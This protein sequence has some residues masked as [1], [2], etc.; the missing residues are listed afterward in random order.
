[1]SSAG[2]VGAAGRS[3][4]IAGGGPG[5]LA[6]ALC[7]SRTGWDVTVLERGPGPDR[8]GAAIA[9]QP[10]GLAVLDALG[11][12]GRLVERGSGVP[13]LVVYTPSGDVL[14]EI[15]PPPFLGHHAAV[16]VR[17][18]VL[19]DV[20]TEA[21][22]A[23]PNVELRYDTAVLA[24][25]RHG[26]VKVVPAGSVASSHDGT[27]DDD[28]FEDDTF[29]DDR[30]GGATIDRIAS[31]ATSA[32]T[33]A[34][35][36]DLV[37]GADGVGSRVRRSGAFGP[38]PI[39]SRYR[40]A[41]WIIE[42][43]VGQQPGECWS[44]G[45]LMGWADIGD[46]HSYW[47][48]SLGDP[49][50]SAAVDEGDRDRFVRRW[51]TLVPFVADGIALLPDLDRVLVNEAPRVRCRRWVDGRV[52]LLGD[53]AHAMAP[54]LGQGANS[55]FVDAAVLALAVR[56][57][58]VTQGLDDYQRSR[59]RKVA[60]VQ[61]SADLLARVSHIE[62]PVVRRIRDRVVGAAAHPRLV[63]GQ[64]RAA[65]Q[66]DPAGLRSDLRAVLG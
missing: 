48:A 39:T 4:L 6:A 64:V 42:G 33:G 54:N 13:A 46:G 17:R 20:L 62:Q 1:M 26:R 9:L 41:R 57:G 66:V 52:A 11:V 29:E 55:A 22:A 8:T 36:A 16:V 56:E 15:S 63:A 53:A 19:A 25:D 44:P 50:V 40:Y 14:Q 30:S 27:I 65:F 28:M 60:R 49:E 58:P 35:E 43:V 5:G 59:R 51:Q 21:I 45:G 12:A 34:L 38:G 2:R 10:N 31:G 7:L 32:G 37:V 23:R 18:S 3:A 61:R 24:A 47:Y